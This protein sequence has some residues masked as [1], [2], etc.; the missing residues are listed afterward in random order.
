MSR[1]EVKTVI[2][3]KGVSKTFKTPQGPVTALKDVS[4]TVSRG[5]VLG[6]FGQS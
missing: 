4:L 2:S 1:V 6:I 5:E 3:V